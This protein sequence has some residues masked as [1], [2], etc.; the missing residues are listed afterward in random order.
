ML[1]R[2]TG[3]VAKYQGEVREAASKAPAMDERL[4][5]RQVNEWN[6]Q[7]RA[8]ATERETVT[9]GGIEAAPPPYSPADE[10]IEGLRGPEPAR[11]RPVVVM[12]GPDG[13]AIVWREGENSAGPE[14]R[15]NGIWGR[16]AA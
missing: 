8:R 16:W 3:G 7:G 13:H 14:T 9:V 1:F 10:H 11:I 6:G 15:Q 12:V 5:S 4:D 2:S